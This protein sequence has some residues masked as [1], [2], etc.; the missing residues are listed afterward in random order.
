ML[1][2]MLYISKY[3]VGFIYVNWSFRGNSNVFYQLFSLHAYL[4]TCSLCSCWSPHC[5][6]RMEFEGLTGAHAREV[7]DHAHLQ[8]TAEAAMSALRYNSVDGTCLILF[9]NFVLGMIC[10]RPETIRA[11]LLD[12]PPCDEVLIFVHLHSSESFNVIFLNE[13]H[14]FVKGS[15]MLYP[16]ATLTLITKSF[17]FPL[18]LVFLQ[19]ESLQVLLR[20]ALELKTRDSAAGSRVLAGAENDIGSGARRDAH[21]E[22]SY[23]TLAF[24][25]LHEWHSWNYP[26]A[27]KNACI[28]LCNFNLC[29]YS[30]AVCQCTRKNTL[31]VAHWYLQRMVV[32][33]LAPLSKFDLGGYWAAF[34]FPCLDG[35]K[36]IWQDFGQKRYFLS[37]KARQDI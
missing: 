24:S 1:Y 14:T 27:K 4:S 22:H 7:A 19:L 30:C 17:E 28:H 3:Y 10:R 37:H 23:G 16:R 18:H 35:K 33:A 34:L 31:S 21:Q 2:S 32:Y 8:R 26:A 36:P 13:E 12:G 9:W 6:Q 29:S 11:L 5:L 15:F 25:T 20:R